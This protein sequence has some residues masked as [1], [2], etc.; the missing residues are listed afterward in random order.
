MSEHLSKQNKLTADFFIDITPDTC[1]MTFVKT[2][3]QLEKMQTGQI[4][5]VLLNGGEPLKNVPLS[6]EELGHV[7]LSIRKNTEAE[8]Y[9]IF[10]RKE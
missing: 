9:T 1:P 2:K 7:I 4:L 5:E 6:A 3:L 8:N 10:I